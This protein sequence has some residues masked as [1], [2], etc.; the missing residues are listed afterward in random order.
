MKNTYIA[1]DGRVIPFQLLAVV[2]DLKEG[3][4]IVVTRRGKNYIAEAGTTA[5]A[6][7]PPPETVQQT[8]ARNLVRIMYN[9]D[10]TGTMLAEWSGVGVNTVY[11]AR[12]GRRNITLDNLAAIAKALQRPIKDFFEE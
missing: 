7:K 4:S 1:I 11:S 5:T 8:I 2:A 12:S 10:V 6:Y 9:E 3:R